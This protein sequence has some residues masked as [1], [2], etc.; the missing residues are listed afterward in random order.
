MFKREELLAFLKNGTPMRGVPA[1]FWM[2]FPV[3]AQ[4]GGAAID[5]HMQY[6]GETGVPLVKI[7][8]EHPYRLA[9]R[10][11]TPED[12]RKVRP[13]KLEDTDYPAFLDEIRMLRARM[14]EDALILATIHGVLVSAC[15]ATDGM[16]KFPDLN[17]TIT[18]HL[19]ENPEATAVGLNAIADTLKRLSA[20]CI[21]AGADGIYY[22]ALGAEE[23]RFSEA[24]YTTYV[25][26]LECDLLGS[27]ME[28]GAVFLHICKDH[29]R[30]PMFQGYPCHVVNW[31]EHSSSYTLEDGA[32][33][34]GVVGGAVEKERVDSERRGH[35]VP[36]D[37]AE[38][39][40]GGPFGHTGDQPGKGDRLI[41]RPG[42]RPPGR[43]RLRDPLLH[44][45]AV[46]QFRF[47]TGRCF[48][49][50]GPVA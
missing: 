26:P 35:L 45:V 13:L 37:G 25:K 11:E 23:E 36:H 1:G 19:K 50:T 16:G 44:D 30:L 14:G 39:L 34:F 43:N 49:Q 3:T 6:Y 22:A 10:I 42:A 33:L 5:A 4:H 28:R 47:G 18:R 2:H 21:E 20:A 29:P 27:L 17:N 31:A 12:W 8:N 38:L 9:E 41:A 7:M 46:D 24:L 15:H 48:E 40:S 32:A